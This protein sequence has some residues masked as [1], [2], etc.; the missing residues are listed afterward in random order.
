[1]WARGLDRARRYAGWLAGAVGIV[2]TYL[3]SFDLLKKFW[4]DQ[5]PPA[6]V[7]DAYVFVG[8]LAG[9]AYV[10]WR[11]WALMR[12]ERYA[13]A[14]ASLHHA[15]HEVRNLQT[16]IELN[17][18][19]DGF[20]ADHHRRFRGDCKVIAS[21]ALDHVSRAFGTVT[22]THC[23]ASIKLFYEKDGQAY[24][25]TLARDG[26]SAQ[27]LEEMDRRRVEAD[28]D[29]LKGNRKMAALFDDANEDWRYLCN[30][31]TREGGFAS[32]SITAYKPDR[33]TSVVAD[34][35]EWPLPY[36]STLTA[37]IRQGSFTLCEEVSRTIGFLCVDSEA[38]GVFEDRWDTQF[39]FTVA[40]AMY[41]PLKGYSEAVQRAAAAGTPAR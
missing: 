3:S 31:L 24:V 10:C 37:V 4:G 1:M 29:P 27:R 12:K 25:Y 21:R 28:H 2:L 41:H 30:D 19:K 40:D 34:R 39:L 15:M 32:T 35:R 18:R 38:R 14:L 6:L 36:R 17:E 8:L 22:S 11:Q 7:A 20:D 13:G 23:R 33:A 26:A 5:D 16:Y 9:S